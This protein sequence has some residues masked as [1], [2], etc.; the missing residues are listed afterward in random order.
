MEYKRD[1]IQDMIDEFQSKNKDRTERYTSFDYCFNHFKQPSE[2]IL[3][4]MEKSCLAIGFYLASWGMLRGSSFLLT[5]SIQHYKPLV[6]YIASADKNL[7]DIDVD[8]YTT[9][10]NIDKIITVYSEIKEIIIGDDNKYA[11]LT[12]VTKIMLGVFGM[13]PA[14]DSF[15]CKSFKEIFNGCG[16][17]VVNQKSLKCISDFYIANKIDID[18]ASNDIFTK[19]YTSFQSTKFNYTKAKIIDMY[20]FTRGNQLSNNKVV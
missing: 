9:D 1:N 4:D 15:F 5:K 19:E 13:I 6:K 14:F 18:T 8:N 20:G 2:Y 3:K 16:F 10:T 12:L 11:H 17:T 7:W